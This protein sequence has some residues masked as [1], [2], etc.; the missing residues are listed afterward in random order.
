VKLTGIFA[1]I[2]TPFD[3]RGDL[4]TTK[5]QQ[6]VGRWNRTSLSGYLVCGSAGEGGL[7]TVDE[8]VHVWEQV[9]ATAKSDATL[10]A[11]T[12]AESVRETVRL[13][14]RAA[15]IGYT[16]VVVAPPR[17]AAG[18]GPVP[19]MLR[20]YY[21]PVADASRVPVIVENSADG[22]DSWLSTET[23]RVLAQHPNIIA[24]R[25]GT[26]SSRAGDSSGCVKSSGCVRSMDSESPE[27]QILAGDAC[28]LVA[29]L[30][31]GACGAILDFAAAAPFLCLSAEEA[32]RTRQ[33]AAAEELQGL[34]AHP[35]RALAT[36]YGI[37]G[38][39]FA[40]DLQ[41]Y[42]GGSPRLPGLPINAD[43]KKHIE[44]L[45]REITG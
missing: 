23:L 24:V 6:N 26:D 39:K 12:G 10:L 14:D 32:V 2:P 19:E 4:Y 45:F 7:L 44:N 17:C 42:Y 11:A 1:S 33:A 9:A 18:V 15:E 21:Q 40:M 36:R 38:L 27:L 20:A 13:S 34:M 31:A 22:P 5:I 3:H 41:G 28:G 37:A 30:D 43:G 25:Q 29:S 35:A 8:K 16:A